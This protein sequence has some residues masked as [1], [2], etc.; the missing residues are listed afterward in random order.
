M[1]ITGVSPLPL[2][3]NILGQGTQP[4]P[5]K[6]YMTGVS[7]LP[8]S[9]NVLSQGTQP[10]P[11]KMYMTGVSPLPLSQNIEAKNRYD[12]SNLNEI[13]GVSPLPLSQYAE[14]NNIKVEITKT[15]LD[16]EDEHS[17]IDISDESKT[18]LC[19]SSENTDKF[20]ADLY[21]TNAK[22]HDKVSAVIHIA[23]SHS[24]CEE[25]KNCSLDDIMSLTLK[26]SVV[27]ITDVTPPNS[28][29]GDYYSEIDTQETL[30][31]SAKESQINNA[32]EEEQTDQEF[33]LSPEKNMEKELLISD[34]EIDNQKPTAELPIVNADSNA[35][36]SKRKLILSP[37]R[38]THRQKMHKSNLSTL[39]SIRTEIYKMMKTDETLT[40]AILGENE[41]YLSF[42]DSVIKME[43]HLEP[44]EL[45][46][47][48][49]IKSVDFS[50]HLNNGK[51]L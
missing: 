46:E 31:V 32:T 18:I 5:G 42:Y 17:Y 34:P 41:Y 27:N 16:F 9:Q 10:S 1:E 38:V 19:N 8:L 51:L 48:Q 50:L 28:S 37:N 45:N 11:S 7:P 49:V 20:A 44:K 14:P 4:S 2:S 30:T 12:E 25:N 22:V 47:Y 23:A 36:S 24:P 39:S 3:Q 40:D 43:V 35:E 15:K 33:R 21:G 6:M 13:T 26:T 29:H